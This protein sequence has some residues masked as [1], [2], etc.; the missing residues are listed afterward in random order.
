MKKIL[1]ILIILLLF[2]AC[3]LP[4]SDDYSQDP[5]VQ[6]SVSLILTQ[7]A[8]TNEATRLVQDATPLPVETET[9]PAETQAEKETATQTQPEQNQPEPSQTPSPTELVSTDPWGGEVTFSENFDSG[10]YWDFESGFLRS[11][12]K[13]G[14]LEFTSK[15]TP[16]WSS[17]YTTKPEFKN[18]YVETSFS[19]PNCQGQDRFGLVI[20]WNRPGVFYYM[21]VTCDGTW[22]F[23]LYTASNETIDILPYTESDNFSPLAENHQIGILAK[24]NS[25]EFYIN[26]Q[27]VGSVT[28]DA[29]VEGGNF[30][31][32]S[33]S[34]GTN[35]FQTL[36]DRLEYWQ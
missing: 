21:G 32:M 27:R 4:G 12:I 30:G 10:D 9:L 29:I 14:Q 7:G 17:W 36:I 6:T 20:R 16:W 23:T 11:Q 8:Q 24:D 33:M 25:F 18:G 31:F 15:G 5:V 26:R 22:G 13:N 1:P 35:N 28:S 3:N 34:S 2:S 19:M